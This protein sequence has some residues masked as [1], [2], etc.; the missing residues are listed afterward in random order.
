M[1]PTSYIC[2]M[3][4]QT[5]QLY[6]PDVKCKRSNPPVISVRCGIK[7]TQLCLP[8]SRCVVK[9]TSYICQIG[10]QTHQLYLPD[11]GNKT[12]IYICYVGGQ[13]HQ[14][15]LPDWRSNPPVISAM[16]E[17]KP[18]SYICYVGGQTHQLYL[19]YGR[20]NPPVISA[21][22]EVKPTSYI[23]YVGG[24]TH[25]LYLLCGRSTHQ[26]YLLNGRSNPPFLPHQMW[27][28]THHLY[29]IVVKLVNP[30]LILVMPNMLSIF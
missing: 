27:D 1:K 20:S 5:C 12:T 19:L 2:Q 3:G 14:L 23:C 10:D 26:L 9:T 6:R 8:D 24:Q 21:M 25:Q 22:L 11:V 16:L 18:T 7:S 29:H 4:G 30:P 28:Q 13:T 17:V 15:Y